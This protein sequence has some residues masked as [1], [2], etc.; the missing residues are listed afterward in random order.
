M[1]EKTAL[2][3]RVLELEEQLESYRGSSS[4]VSDSA[5]TLDQELENIRYFLFC[6]LIN[7]KKVFECYDLFCENYVNV[8]NFLNFFALCGCNFF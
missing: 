5:Q 8:V 6:Y 3:A 1:Q 7:I 4:N 2:K